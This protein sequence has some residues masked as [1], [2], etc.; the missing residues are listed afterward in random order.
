MNAV[1]MNVSGYKNQLTFMKEYPIVKADG[2]FIWITN[3]ESTVQRYHESR[4][5]IVKEDLI[6]KT[7][8]FD[9]ANVNHPSHYTAGNIEVIDFIEDKKLGYHR[10]N[11]I[12]YICRAGLKDK[13]KEIED[14]KKAEWYIKREIERLQRN[15]R[16][17]TQRSS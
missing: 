11:A 14:L 6:K 15:G 13:N 4:F 16:E 5:K 3:D 1:C 17:E 7:Q 10:G 9:N 12:K 2:E 8:T